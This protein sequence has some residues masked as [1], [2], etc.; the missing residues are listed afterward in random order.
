[1]TEIHDS[2]DRVPVLGNCIRETCFSFSK[3]PGQ[4]LRTYSVYRRV[5][6]YVER[7]IVYERVLYAHNEVHTFVLVYRNCALCPAAIRDNQQLTMV[8]QEAKSEHPVY[9][10]GN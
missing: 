4:D 8:A 1:M 2:H 9:H 5:A 6:T 7:G 10:Q 3:C